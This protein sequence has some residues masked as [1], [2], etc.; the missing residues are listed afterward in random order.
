MGGFWKRAPFMGFIA[1]VFVMASLGLPGL[2]NFVAEFLTLVGAWSAN[3]TLT[4][5]ATIGLVGATAYS[6]R[7]MQRVFYGDHSGTDHEVHDLS[8]REKVMMLSLVIIILW[9]GFFPQ[10]VLDTSRTPVMEAMGLKPRQVKELPYRAK[11]TII[12]PRKGDQYE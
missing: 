6:L 7:I 1:I 9:L 5:F 4:V 2:G 11:N 3:Q 8:L 12:T 10:T